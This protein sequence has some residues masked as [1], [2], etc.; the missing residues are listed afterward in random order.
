[1]FCMQTTEPQ[2]PSLSIMQ[3]SK[4]TL[5]SRSGRPPLPTVSLVSSASS[6]LT[7]C[8]TASRALPPDFK[9]SQ[10][11]SVAL[12]KFQ[13]Q[14]TIGFTAVCAEMVEAGATSGFVSVLQATNVEAETSPAADRLEFLMNLRRSMGW[15]V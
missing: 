9:T 11:F 14:T 15:Y 13:V 6:T 3:A 4:V 7:P 12:K 2:L 1:M 5:P 10:A 8:S